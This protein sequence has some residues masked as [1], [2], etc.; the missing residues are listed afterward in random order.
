MALDINFITENILSFYDFKRKDVVHVG[1]GDGQLIAYSRIAREV[2]AIDVDAQA[3]KKLE[4]RIAEENLT[5]K[6]FA[7]EGDFMNFKGMADVVF[8]EFCLHEMD[9]PLAALKHAKQMYAHVI[10]LDHIPNSKWSWYTLEDEKLAKSWKAISEF[11][12]KKEERYTLNQ[13]Y[14]TYDDLASKLSVL[15]DKSIERIQE[16]KN[17][18]KISIPMPFSLILI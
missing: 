11:K 17:C 8:F 12:I 13:E 3:I 14:D 1:A 6:I 9:D 15:G 18:D 16:L 5:H 7:I 4:R 2:N 10:I